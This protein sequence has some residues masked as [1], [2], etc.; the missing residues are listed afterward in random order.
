MALLWHPEVSTSRRTSTIVRDPGA[1]RYPTWSWASI[2][3]PVCY[4]EPNAWVETLVRWRSNS[5]QPGAMEA[6]T[7]RRLEEPNDFDEHEPSENKKSLILAVSWSFGCIEADWPFKPL[8][9]STFEEIQVNLRTVAHEPDTLCSKWYQMLPEPML[10][11][12]EQE[13]GHGKIPE[14]L[15]N[16]AQT[17]IFKVKTHEPFGHYHTGGRSLDVLNDMGE[18]IGI[19]NSEDASVKNYLTWSLEKGIGEIECMGI[20]LGTRSDMTCLMPALS[21]NMGILSWMSALRDRPELDLTFRDRAGHIL[22]AR[23]VSSSLPSFPVVNVMA[24]RWQGPYAYRVTIG[25]ILLTKWVKT[26]REFKDV[27]LR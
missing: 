23:Y 14:A 18:C 19:L 15:T 7:P 10:P 8:S 17:P 13:G 9:E 24:I 20:S 21:S 22:S 3:E 12:P 16:R 5:P 4:N 6:R 26:K 1:E 11:V 27:L 2:T 25:W